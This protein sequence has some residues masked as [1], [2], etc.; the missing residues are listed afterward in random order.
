MRLAVIVWALFQ[1]HPFVVLALL[2][3]YM[4]SMS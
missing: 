3:S 1:G 4:N 2:V